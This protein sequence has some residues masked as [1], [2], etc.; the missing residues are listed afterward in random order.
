MRSGVSVGVIVAAAALLALLVYGVAARDSDT[1]L[2]EAIRRGERVVA[3]GTQRSLPLLGV[4]GTDSL[5][6]HRGKV[7][8]LNFWASWCEPCRTE[9]PA[10]QRA[11]RR[12][13]RR[14]AEVL[15]VNWRDTEDDAQRFARQYGVTY[16]SL[17]DVDGELA[18]D[19]GTRALPETFVVDRQ[20]RIAA[21]NRG[22]VDSAFLDRSIRRLLAP[23]G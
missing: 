23:A 9:M 10:L 5:K 19:Y 7:V 13:A 22:E 16:R 14:G 17:R 4:T 21:I 12:W 8:V 15:G 1:S 3:P 18:S 11:H 20:G 2:D 6:A